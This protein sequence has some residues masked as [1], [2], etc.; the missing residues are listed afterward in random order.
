MV[1]NELLKSVEK[2]IDREIGKL[3]ID[4]QRH[5][6]NRGGHHVTA[7]E[8]AAGCAAIETHLTVINGHMIQIYRAGHIVTGDAIVSIEKGTLY[9]QSG[10]MSYQMGEGDIIAV[11]TW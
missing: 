4:F 11:I 3:L 5:S 7:E 1:K 8:A 6:V 9:V 2:F 10:E